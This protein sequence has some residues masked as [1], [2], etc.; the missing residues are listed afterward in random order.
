MNNLLTPDCNIEVLKE[1][2]TVPAA[3][4]PAGLG[5]FLAGAAAKMGVALS[6]DGIKVNINHPY[7]GYGELIINENAITINGEN[8]EAE[9]LALAYIRQLSAI[10]DGKL[11][12][13]HIRYDA[14]EQ[15][16]RGIHLDCSR[17]FFST[18]EIRRLLSVFA[19]LG[20]NFFHWH[21]TDD[22]GWRFPVE[23]YPLLEEISSK[24]LD[25]EYDDGR[26][27][28]GF[29]S[30][31][32][33]KDIIEYAKA[34]GITVIP[35]IELPGHATALLAAYPEFGCTGKKLSVPKK[36]GVFEDVMNPASKPLWIFIEK[37]IGTLASIFPGPYIHI[38]GDECPHVQWETNSDCQK[39]MKENNLKDTM[40]L[41]GWF[42]SRVA[43]IVKANGRR[44]IGWDEIVDAPDID[45]D[46]II[47]SW[48]GLEGAR[49]ATAR[50][51]QVILCPEAGGGCYFDRHHTSDDWE[52][53]NL[54]ISPLN[55]VFDLDFNMKELKK[56]E[57]ALILGG[58]GNM[59]TEKLRFGRSIEYMYFPRAFALAENLWRGDGRNWDEFQSRR[60][61]IYK[62][63]IDLD[64][65]FSTARWVD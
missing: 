59:W 32:D 38:G 9:L 52:P 14:P 11:P 62:L 1:D 36:W 27:E 35:E 37:A 7:E 13:C 39:I 65:A 29:Y 58:Q 34:L 22:Q 48:R 47:M 21:L 26:T 33:M 40:E 53:G 16:Y 18:N 44:A 3:L 25:P 8:E 43:S 56:E 30:V 63:L 2:L 4:D 24:R 57:R 23:G 31:S 19:V 60:K 5:E 12:I 50:G 51:H 17:H 49:K 55:C 46:V 6:E 61:N 41:Q 20:F 64:M 15:G 28:G 54:T 42:T 10:Y 45:R